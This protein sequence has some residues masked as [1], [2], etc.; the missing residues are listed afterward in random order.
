MMTNIAI[1]NVSNWYTH[2]P[3]KNSTMNSRT[4]IELL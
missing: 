3:K 1:I 2:Q 4:I